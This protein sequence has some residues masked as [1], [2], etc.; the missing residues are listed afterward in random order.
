[1][2]KGAAIQL[3]SA[4]DNINLMEDE[5]KSLSKDDFTK[6]NNLFKISKD[7]EEIF[8]DVASP[9]KSSGTTNLFRRIFGRLTKG[10][11]RIRLRICQLMDDI[12]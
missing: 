6:A 10:K 2:D 7:F 1:M 5:M 11:Y 12:L 9:C 4:L 8:S 3:L